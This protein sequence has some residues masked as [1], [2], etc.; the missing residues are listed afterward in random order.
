MT[1]HLAHIIDHSTEDSFYGNISLTRSHFILTWM[2]KRV[3]ADKSLLTKLDDQTFSLECN[4]NLTISTF[5]D[6]QDLHLLIELKKGKCYPATV[7]ELSTKKSIWGCISHSRHEFCLS[8]SHVQIQGDIRSLEK[9]DD[10]VFHFKSTTLMHLED[11]LGFIPV[12]CNLLI[13]IH[14]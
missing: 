11:E 4:S 6:P 14:K 13:E 2:D 3:Y 12:F 1:N 5:D 9:V 10:N 7:L 8:V